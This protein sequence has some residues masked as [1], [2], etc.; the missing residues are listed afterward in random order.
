MRQRAWMAGASSM[1]AV[2]AVLGSPGY[3]PLQDVGEIGRLWPGAHL[4]RHSPAT[5]AQ[6]GLNKDWSAGDAGNDCRTYRSRCRYIGRYRNWLCC[7]M[8]RRRSTDYSRW[9]S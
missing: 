5:P 8:V 2:R 9:T 7:R 6:W 1:A 3:D 4:A